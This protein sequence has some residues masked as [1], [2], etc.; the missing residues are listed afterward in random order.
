MRLP[1]L[2]AA[3]ALASSAATIDNP[4]LDK[5]LPIP[6][7][8]IRAEHVEPAMTRLLEEARRKR[9][10]Y[11]A[12]TDLRT[13]ENTMTAL[14]EIT[15]DLVRA[16]AIIRH[17][18]NVA[19]TPVLRKAVGAVLPR[20]AEFV[21][22][23][24]LDPGIYAKL[25][26]FAATPEAKA[27]TGARRRFLEVTLDDFLRQGAELDAP[28]R[29]RL[30]EINVELTNLRKQYGDNVLDATN[31]FELVVRDEASLAG[32]P[33]SARTAARE[34]AKQKGL[35]GWRFTLQ[36]PSYR[37]I[38][39]Y[40]DDAGIREQ[41]FR[42]YNSR[43]IGG[44]N[45]NVPIMR[46]ILQLRQERARLLGFRSYADLTTADRMARSGDRVREFLGTLE[47]RTRPFYE[48]ENA[49][50]LKFRR[51]LEGDRAPELQMWD[52]AYY[53]E[54]LRRQRYDFDEEALR[55][56]FPAGSVLKGMFELV[57]RLYGIRVVK[58]NRA[59]VWNP[60]VEYF[61]VRDADGSLLG[62]FYS[63]LYPREDKRSGAWSSRLITGGPI[64]GRFGP[65]V[66]TINANL[67]QPSDGKPALLSKRDV[68]TV[69]HEFGHLLH[70]V[71]SRVPVRGL[72]D[73]AWDFVEL[74]SQIMENWTWERESLDLIARHYQTGA[75]IPDDLFKKMTLTRTFRAANAQMRQLS[76]GVVDLSLHVDYDASRDPDM[77]AYTRRIFQRFVPS[78]VPA[79][80]AMA[81][82]FTHIFSG[83]YACGYYSYKWAEVLDADA[84]TRFQ[85]E[86]LF[87]AKAGTA[88]RRE[89]LEK[90]NTEEP[91]VL[92]RNFV[93]R[94][95]DPEALMRRSGLVRD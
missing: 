10:A 89:V 72:N 29:K 80:Y 37:A 30:G 26:A 74:P 27:L 41:L 71:L 59:P 52:T 7:D 92:F 22:N 18:D 93:G 1:A 6:F 67:N 50:L 5:S 64:D 49:E 28:A 40:L 63:D 88:F 79:D 95:P 83:G 68:E 47:S 11:V 45:D 24:P 94:D 32:L 16:N 3:A 21:S 85:K 90:G 66:G 91:G 34:S 82:S 39:T 12:S 87:S 51:E 61:E 33:L 13:Y 62:A 70:Q 77:L 48:T 84:F 46:K 19:S 2:L 23:L 9:A 31:A 35:E 14:E 75:P 56:Y 54:K 58:V 42:A 69:Y 38:M 57:E 36:E 43:A 53:A 8:R 25:K 81:A 78:P 15:E 76:L 20:Y 73:V 60:A 17:L 65:H 86:G 44:G 55:P 4:L